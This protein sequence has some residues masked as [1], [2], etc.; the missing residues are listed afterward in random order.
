M[1]VDHR[2]GEDGE[3]KRFAG[4]AEH[5]GRWDGFDGGVGVD[6]VAAAAFGGGGKREDGGVVGEDIVGGSAGVG[7]WVAVGREVGGDGG[8]G[9]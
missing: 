7:R 6:T 8:G 9:L 4:V 5:G 3:R 1:A 2:A